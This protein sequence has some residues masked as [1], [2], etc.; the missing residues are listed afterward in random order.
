MTWEV[1]M[2]DSWEER[3][4]KWRDESLTVF[5]GKLLCD[6]EVNF[7]FVQCFYYLALEIRQRHDFNTFDGS[8]S[9]EPMVGYLLAIDEVE[10]GDPACLDTVPLVLCQNDEAARRVN[11]ALA[12]LIQGIA[13]SVTSYSDPRW[14]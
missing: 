14:N 2:A 10:P 1:G 11:I 13:D 5:V 7:V 3:V 4:R 6:P 9:G 8:L 12:V